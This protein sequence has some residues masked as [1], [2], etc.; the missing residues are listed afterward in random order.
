MFDPLFSV[1]NFHSHTPK[2]QY[3]LA[4]SLAVLSPFRQICYQ[5]QKWLK[6]NVEP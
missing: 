5:E 1:E 4:K 2:A 6:I 3:N